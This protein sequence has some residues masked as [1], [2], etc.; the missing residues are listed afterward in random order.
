MDLQSDPEL[1]KET[2]LIPMH[3]L[4]MAVDCP[5]ERVCS[6]PQKKKKEKKLKPNKIE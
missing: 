1:G 5:Q 6:I 2:G 4:L 3:S